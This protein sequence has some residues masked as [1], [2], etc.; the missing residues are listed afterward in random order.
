MKADAIICSDIHLTL[1]QPKSWTTD[2]LKAQ[3]EAFKHIR[4]LQKKH[5]C[6]VIVPGDL[7]DKWNCSHELVAWCFDNLPKE[8]VCI[9]GN[10]DLPYHKLE[11]LSR[12]PLNV[13]YRAS[14]VLL[15]PY[16]FKHSDGRLIALRGYPYG[17]SLGEY[18]G[19]KCYRHI[20]L[21]HVMTYNKFKP[22]KGCTSDNASQVIKKLKGYDL[23]V[24]GDNHI[25]F[26]K[27]VGNQLLVNPGS[28]LPTKADQI[29]HKPRVYLWNAESNT[30]VK[31]YL[32]IEIHM[33]RKHIEAKQQDSH[34]IE[35]FVKKLKKNKNITLDYK[36]NLKRTISKNKVRESV[37]EIIW[38]AVS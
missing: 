31:K 7:F 10:H 4:R 28:L 13:L 24:T 21:C 19:R 23:I 30:V 12:T 37:K 38:K 25:P 26:T 29:D 14:R 17:T 8:I 6:P 27:K 2:Y 32:P 15:P 33:T 1:K 35:A 20:A 34:R 5:N 36:E 3:D 11:L 16:R 22:F 9:A 18:K